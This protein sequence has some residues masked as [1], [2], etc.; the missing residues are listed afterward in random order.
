MMAYCKSDV[1]LLKEGCICFQREFQTHADFNPM[2]KTI[3]IASACHRFWRKKML[4]TKKVAIEPLRG[5]HGV[6]TAQSVKALH[7][8]T[9][10]EQLLREN[11]PTS[12]AAEECD[13]IKRKG[14]EGEVTLTTGTHSYQVDGF[15]PLTNTVYE[16]HGCLYH[17]CPCCF[18]KRDQKPFLH[19]GQTFAEVYEET[20]HKESELRRAGYRLI[21]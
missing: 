13:R 7:W 4:P 3:T 5:W 1:K 6:H 11:T 20:K 14:N 15:D 16:F 12:S 17:G 8:L 9:W 2:E 19:Y 18:P 21:V 10:E